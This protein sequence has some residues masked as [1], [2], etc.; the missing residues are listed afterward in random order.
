MIHRK[1]PHLDTSG[2]MGRERH[3]ESRLNRSGD[4]LFE[5]PSQERFVPRCCQRPATGVYPDLRC[6]IFQRSTLNKHST[7]N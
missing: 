2:D 1:A 3:A 4:R 5:L 7:I 6:L